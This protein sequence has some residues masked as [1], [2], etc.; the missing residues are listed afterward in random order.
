MFTFVYPGTRVYVFFYDKDRYKGTVEG[1]CGNFNNMDSDELLSNLNG[2]S[3]IATT[4]QEFGNS[5]KVGE[6][7]DVVEKEVVTTPCEVSPCWFFKDCLMT[8]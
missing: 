5:W 1:M 8:W 2:S 7:P 6:C 4:P 3:T